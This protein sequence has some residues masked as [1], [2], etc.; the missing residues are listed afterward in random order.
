[1]KVTVKRNKKGDVSVI[2]KADGR[3]HKE[4]VDLKEAVL[5]AVKDGGTISPAK[6]IQELESRGYGAEGPPRK[7][8]AAS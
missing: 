4:G 2:F 5:A 7:K 8:G 1:M 6:V 3:R